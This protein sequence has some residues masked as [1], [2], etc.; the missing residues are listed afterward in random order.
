[1]SGRWTRRAR[2]KRG[3][4]RNPKPREG[5]SPERERQ[6]LPRR[7]TWRTGPVGRQWRRP[8]AA[9]LC[10]GAPG[11][12]RRRVVG[13][14]AAGSAKPP[15]TL[16]RGPATAAP[17]APGPACK[18]SQAPLPGP[19]AVL[20]PLPSAPQQ[21]SPA[22]ESGSRGASPCRCPAGAAHPAAIWEPRF[23]Q[24]GA[25][26]HAGRRGPRPRRPPRGLPRGGRG[27]SALLPGARGRA[28]PSEGCGPFS[29][30]LRRRPPSPRPRPHGRPAPRPGPGQTDGGRDPA[31]GNSRRARV[32][33]PG[34]AA[35]RTHR[36]L[37]WGHLTGAPPSRARAPHVPTPRGQRACARTRPA[38]P[39]ERAPYACALPGRRPCSPR[40]SRPAPARARPPPNPRRVLGTPPYLPPEPRPARALPL[41]ASLLPPPRPARP[42]LPGA[43][44]VRPHLSC[45]P[46]SHRP[47][48][49][50]SVRSPRAAAAAGRARRSRPAL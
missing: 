9:A 43:T 22:R 28:I 47:D 45:A 4:G 30:R 33:A 3:A 13:L 21:W 27:G 16:Q 6:G 14:R 46:A 8:A 32:G 15:H 20:R 18:G 7:F 34:P 23:P 26:A 41:A 5:G 39:R 50:R 44:A 11:H 42:A 10:A 24:P 1:M 48:P 35:P 19:R 29:H 37:L 17:R 40:C 49:L 38:G 12:L 36:P 31:A 2:Q 25:A